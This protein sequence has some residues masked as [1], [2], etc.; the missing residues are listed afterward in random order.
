MAYYEEFAILNKLQEGSSINEKTVQQAIKCLKNGGF[1]S[2]SRSSGCFIHKTE[3][4][5]GKPISDQVFEEVLNRLEDDIKIVGDSVL[6]TTYALKNNSISEYKESN[7]ISKEQA[8]ED[9]SNAK[10]N[11][12]YSKHLLDAAK[13]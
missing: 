1:L 10:T 7:E 6:S 2:C 4:S 9:L 11:L 3:D 13:T 12:Y 8:K 5:L